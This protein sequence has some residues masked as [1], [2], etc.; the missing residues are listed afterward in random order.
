MSGYLRRIRDF[1]PDIKLFLLYN[2]LANVGF[3]VTE[4]IFNLYLLELG[5]QED[6]IGEWRAIQT[7]AMAAGSA[8]VGAVL[9]RFGIWQGIVGGFSLLIAAS[10]SLALTESATLLL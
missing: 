8:S 6:Y 3:G 1:N 10:V 2:L 7:C 5:F 4:L 9:N